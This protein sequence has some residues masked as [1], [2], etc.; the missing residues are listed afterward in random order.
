MLQYLVICDTTYSARTLSTFRRNVL[1]SSPVL[2]NNIE[3]DLLVACLL[4]V[5]CLAYAFSETAVRVYQI[6]R[7]CILLQNVKKFPRCGDPSRAVP[8]RIRVEIALYG[9]HLKK[10]TGPISKTF[11]LLYEYNRVAH[12][13]KS[14]TYVVHPFFSLAPDW[15][16]HFYTRPTHSLTNSLINTV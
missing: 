16:R 7:R 12:G 8:T 5:S 3:R 6:T 1:H 13:T 9:P 11:C 10:E 4:L 2:S 14:D 15:M